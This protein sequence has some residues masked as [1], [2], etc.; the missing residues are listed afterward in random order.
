MNQKRRKLGALFG[1]DEQPRQIWKCILWEMG[2]RRSN[3][4]HSHSADG[5]MPIVSNSETVVWLCL[6]V[7]ARATLAAVAWFVC[8][9]TGI[10]WRSQDAGGD[11][12]VLSRQGRNESDTIRAKHSHAQE[13]PH[14]HQGVPQRAPRRGTASP[15]YASIGETLRMLT[16]SAS[17]GNWVQWLRRPMT[18]TC[19]HQEAEI[20]VFSIECDLRNLLTK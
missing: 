1:C 7:A 6:V 2:H 16:S 9:C 19:A 20:S 14:S 4:T 3:R 5:R 13:G 18:H 8:S 10:R 15:R 12:F 17:L 11:Q